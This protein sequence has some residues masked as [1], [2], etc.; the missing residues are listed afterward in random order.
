MV[1]EDE[2]VHL[3][4]ARCQDLSFPV[5]SEQYERFNRYIQKNSYNGKLKLVNLGLAIDSSKAIYDILSGNTNI[6]RLYIGQNNLHDEGAKV[7]AECLNVANNLIHLDI[8]SNNISPLGLE[9]ILNNLYNN[10]TLVSLNLSSPDRSRR[11]KLGVRGAEMVRNLLQC[12]KFIQY[13]NVSS[14][15]LLN[16][17]AELILEGIQGNPNIVS[18]IMKANEM[19]HVVMKQLTDAVVASGIEYLDISQNNIGNAG[20]SDL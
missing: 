4:T 2:L 10:N 3:F 9:P 1:N 20:M 7:I 18:L 19:T 6:K 14:T 5:N 11:N 16:E 17:G 8:S 13:I 15:A 12:S